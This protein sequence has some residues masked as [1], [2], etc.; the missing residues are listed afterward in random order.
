MDSAPKDSVTK[1]ALKEI[2]NRA[3]EELGESNGELSTKTRSTVIFENLMTDVDFLTESAI[4]GANEPV[5]LKKVLAP[6]PEEVKAKVTSEIDGLMKACYE[7]A[8]PRMKTDMLAMMLTDDKETV[9]MTNSVPFR[10]CTSGWRA[11]SSGRQAACSPS[12]RPPRCSLSARSPPLSGSVLLPGSS[13]FLEESRKRPPSPLCSRFRSPLKRYRAWPIA[14]RLISR[15]GTSFSWKFL[16][17]TS[18][19]TTVW[20]LMAVHLAEI[21]REVP[22]EF[23]GERSYLQFNEVLKMKVERRLAWVPAVANSGKGPSTSGPPTSSLAGCS[24]N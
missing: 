20:A 8:A 12:K 9:Y 1:N 21:M 18:R 14:W 6:T 7:S 11:L 19:C 3:I 13:A 2:E 23:P 10:V 16:S 17:Y 22:A 15:S 4:K 24:R 5:N